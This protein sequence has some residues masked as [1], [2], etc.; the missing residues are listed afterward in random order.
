MACNWHGID[1]EMPYTRIETWHL[2]YILV[3]A[4]VTAIVFRY[5]SS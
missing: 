4:E 5:R 3:P 2:K 1:V